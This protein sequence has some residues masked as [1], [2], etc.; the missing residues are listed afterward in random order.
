MNIALTTRHD[1]Q[2]IAT[3]TVKQAAEIIAKRTILGAPGMTKAAANEWQTY[4]AEPFEKY[5][6][7]PFREN[8][9]QPLT[10]QI[11]QH[12]A[13][14]GLDKTWGEA[15]KF[16]NETPWAQGALLGAG[17]GGLLGLGTGLLGRRR[18]SR[19]F[20]DMLTG[21]LLGGTIGGVGAHYFGQPDKKQEE[22][23]PLGTTITKDP[24][25][26]KPTFSATATPVPKIG[27]GETIGTAEALENARKTVQVASTI[28]NEALRRFGKDDPRLMEITTLTAGIHNNLK[29]RRNNLITNEELLER[30]LALTKQLDNIHRNINL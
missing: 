9:T 30:N 4:V 17:A 7:Q 15:Q 10:K 8:V 13:T 22:P 26:K 2:L 3:G 27:R 14:A 21:G 25:T 16:Y 12:A 6:A 28:G 1:L 23:P 20:S 24:E 5:V 29:A 19:A 11:G 18:K